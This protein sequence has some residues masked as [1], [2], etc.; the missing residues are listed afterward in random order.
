MGTIEYE[1][2]GMQVRWRRL[3]SCMADIVQDV[4]VYFVQQQRCYY[5]DLRIR[6]H[7]DLLRLDVRPSDAFVL[8]VLFGCPVFI[9]NETLEL[10]KQMTS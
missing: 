7:D 3:S 1:M 4:V 10:L 5:A 9:A 8:A 2:Y 6:S